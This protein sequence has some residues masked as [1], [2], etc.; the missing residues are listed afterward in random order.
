MKLKK[1]VDVK[2]DLKLLDL[3]LE[4]LRLWPDLNPIDLPNERETL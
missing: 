2:K 1:E 4:H 3:D